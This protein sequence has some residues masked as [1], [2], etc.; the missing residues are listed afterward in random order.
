MRTKLPMR[1]EA[2]PY[3]AASLWSRLTYRSALPLFRIGVQRPLQ[4]D[5]LP[6]IATRDEPRRHTPN[7]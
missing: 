6:T 1:K 5:D 2:A 3:D 7:R 4:I